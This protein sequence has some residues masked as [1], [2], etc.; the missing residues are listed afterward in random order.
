MKKYEASCQQF[1][2]EAN[3]H[4]TE[5][6]SKVIRE[7]WLLHVDAILMRAFQSVKDAVVLETKVS[8]AEALLNNPMIQPPAKPQD[9]YHKALH[10]QCEA[11]KIYNAAKT[12]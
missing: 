7:G 2:V 9:V 1:G 10:K 8:A 4:S 5:A 11:A 6:A 3:A 12:V